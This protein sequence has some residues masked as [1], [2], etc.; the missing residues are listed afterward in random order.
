MARVVF[1]LLVTGL[2]ATLVS[3]QGSTQAPEAGT[4]LARQG[5]ESRVVPA[6]SVTMFLSFPINA[7]INEDFPAFGLPTTA[8]R[9]KSN[10]SS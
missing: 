7:L 9:G 2:L 4:E 10:R 3:C 1:I 6:I 8:M 5:V